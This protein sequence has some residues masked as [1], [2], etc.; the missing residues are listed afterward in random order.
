MYCGERCKKRAQR[1]PGRPANGTSVPVAGLAQ[2]SPIRES[3]GRVAAMTERKL[4]DAGRLD[5]VM[6]AV[7]MALAA[8][9]DEPGLDTGSSLAAVTRELDRCLERA[10]EGVRVA[11]TPLERQRRSREMKVG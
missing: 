7:A 6:G 10:L 8:K 5:T 4:L 2:V 11:E 3:T 1:N 9:V